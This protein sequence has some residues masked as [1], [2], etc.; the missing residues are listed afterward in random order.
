M[1]AASHSTDK[2]APY[3]YVPADSSHPVTASLSLLVMMLGATAWVNDY[4]LGKWAVYAGLLSLL[5]IIYLWFADAIRE[6]MS[7]L[8]SKRVDLSYRWSM[9]WFIFSEIMFFAAFFGSL[10]YIRVV[11]TPWLGDL[12]HKMLLWPEFNA[13]W[14][15]MGPAGII[16][17]FEVMGPFWLPTI[18]TALLLSSGVTLT[19]AHHALRANH[20]K[21]TTL[22]L[23][24]TVLLGLI[25]AGVQAYEYV[26]AYSALNLRFDSGAFG[27]LFYMLTG[28]HGFHVI[29]GVIMLAVI[30]IRVMK[31]HFTADNH[32]GFEGA[33][34]YWHFV[35]V[36]WLGLY[37]FV[38]WF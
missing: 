25:F 30:M 28:F 33:A 21:S 5:V 26:Y 6:S 8:N 24:A 9:S 32:F 18:N 7:G 4:S 22:W 2:E 11:T 31:G 36:V 10:W 23:G 1:S 13:V 27:S 20:R 15:N 29:L 3:Y 16:E 35:D 34:W 19:F 38:Y 17:N 14:P 37:L 12:D